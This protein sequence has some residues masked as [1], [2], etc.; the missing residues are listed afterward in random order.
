MYRND[1]V[2]TA[3]PVLLT[4]DILLIELQ[5]YSLGTF[6][7]MHHEKATEREWAETAEGQGQRWDV[8]GPAGGGIMCQGREDWKRRRDEDNFGFGAECSAALR[9]QGDPKEVT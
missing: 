3:L 9:C 5:H 1:D 2:D 6:T 7:Q 4:S 8:G